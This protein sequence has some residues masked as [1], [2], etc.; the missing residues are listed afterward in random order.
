MG[1]EPEFSIQKFDI[2]FSPEVVLGASEAMRR[3][4]FITILGGASVGDRSLA[5]HQA[6]LT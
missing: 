3:R 6:F 2:L 5:A 4:E 1:N